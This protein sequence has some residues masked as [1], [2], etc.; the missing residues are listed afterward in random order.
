MDGVQVLSVETLKDYDDGLLAAAFTA[1]LRAVIADLNER[2][3]DDRARKLVLEMSFVP[4]AHAGDLDRV[5]IEYNVKHYIGGHEGREQILTPKI[6][7]KKM[8][9]VFAS[10]GTDARQPHLPMD[11]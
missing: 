5:N 8:N 7:D 3:N 6:M 9:L 11:D 2:P 10:N 1:N 4:S